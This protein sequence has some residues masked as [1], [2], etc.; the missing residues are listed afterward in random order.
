MTSRAQLE[1][2]RHELAECLRFFAVERGPRWKALTASIARVDALLSLS[3]DMANNLAE[4][5]AVRATMVM[6]A[7]IAHGCRTV[8]DIVR[9][10]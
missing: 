4:G 3:D 2:E 1:S 9:R 6:G 5:L 7:D 8:A 10:S